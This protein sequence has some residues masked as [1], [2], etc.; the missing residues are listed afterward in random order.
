MWSF[1]RREFGATWLAYCVVVAYALSWPVAAAVSFDFHEAAFAPPLMAVLFERLSAY[2]A[3][4]ARWWHVALPAFGLLLVKEDMGLFVAAFGLA[5]LVRSVRW[6]G[7]P[8]P[9]RL[10]GAG[11]VLG[12]LAAAVLLT[13][14]VLPA[15]GSNPVYYWRYGQ[16][17]A[18][19]PKAVLDMLSHP[20]LVAHT[21]VTPDV[22]VHTVVALFALVAFVGL[23]SPCL[24]SVVPL[25][26]ER[27]LADAPSWWGM[28]FHYNLFLVVPLLCGGVDA[29]ARLS[30]WLRGWPA[31]RW[32]RPAW[33]VAVLAVAL[34]NV[35]GSAFGSLTRPSTW[36]PTEQTRAAQAAA[37]QVPS[38]VD[39]EA[40]NN[41]GPLLTGRDTVL[42]WD[43]LPRWA[44]WIVADVGRGTF[45]FCSLAEQ[46]DRVASLL[47]HGYRQVFTQDGYVV[48]RTDAPLPPIDTRR[49]PGCPS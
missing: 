13:S 46:R 11:F 4:T 43:R 8:R 40:A 42:L 15:F 30:R 29:V 39:V 21:L 41:V 37:A 14:V 25:L 19:A 1:T 6:P 10:L 49:S 5:V 44:P 20:V 36:Q 31:G 33:V 45:P 48:L 23:L 12:G 2:R 7:P 3:G 9:V 32:L 34:W 24:L 26:V 27:M 22:K 35:P 18:S 28:S 16:F 38:G 17:G 47:L